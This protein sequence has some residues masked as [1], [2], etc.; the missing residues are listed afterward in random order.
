[1]SLYSP[2][3]CPTAPQTYVLRVDIV[4]HALSLAF[5]VLEFIL[6]IIATL[7]YAAEQ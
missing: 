1:M 5:V 6:A 3:P 7:T 4:V 2:F